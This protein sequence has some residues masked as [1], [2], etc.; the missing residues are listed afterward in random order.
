MWILSFTHRKNKKTAVILGMAL[1]L[2]SFAGTIRNPIDER[3]RRDY[4]AE[5]IQ[6]V[7]KI[8]ERLPLGTVV[9]SRKPQMFYLYCGHKSFMYPLT[10]DT[11]VVKTALERA[12]YVMVEPF[13]TVRCMWPVIRAYPVVAA[14]RTGQIILVKTPKKSPPLLSEQPSMLLR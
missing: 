9:V 12:D 10:Q 4:W 8:G 6:F 11:T 13:N 7:G 2:L 1:F 14:S 3:D 5:Y